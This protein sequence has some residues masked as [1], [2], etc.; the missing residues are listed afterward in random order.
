MKQLFL[1]AILSISCS[2]S[3]AQGSTSYVLAS[4][5][6]PSICMELPQERSIVGGTIIKPQYIGNVSKKIKN[7]FE[8][9]CHLWEEKIP[10]TYPLMIGVSRANLGSSV[11]LARV[12]AF[13]AVDNPDEYR[14]YEKRVMQSSDLFFPEDSDYFEQLDAMIEF[15]SNAP[16]DYNTLASEAATD[17]YDFITVAIQAI[18]KALGF[19]ATGTLNTNNQESLFMQPIMAKGNALRYIGTAANNYIGT[20]AWTS[21]RTITVGS[22]P[23]YTFHGASTTNVTP[24][25]GNGNRQLRPNRSETKH[26]KIIPPLLRDEAF[27][28]P[29]RYWDSYWNYREKS[30]LGKY[31]VLKDGSFEEYDTLTALTANEARYARTVDGFLRIKTISRATGY[32]NT[33]VRY[34]LYSYLPQT[35][36]FEAGEDIVPYGSTLRSTTA[37]RMRNPALPNR[38]NYLVEVPIEFKNTEGCDYIV[39]EQVDSDWPVPYYT[40]VD[41]SQGYYYAIVDT[42]YPSTVKLYYENDNGETEGDTIVINLTG[43]QAMAAMPSQLSV[44]SNNSCLQYRILGNDSRSSDSLQGCYTITNANTGIVSQEGSI[45]AASGRIDVSALPAGVYLITIQTGSQTLSAKWVKR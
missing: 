1:L 5:N 41:P 17:K 23:S 8:Y 15:N 19:S 25:A 45:S 11:I 12:T 40:N 10:T 2:S 42:R 4:D 37:G 7:A 20:I 21:D 38:T 14:A 33:D 44:S 43:S 22:G 9:A 18:F 6:A 35:P 39:A 30:G 26:E 34:G 3:F 36:D 24:Y 13:S 28:F 16:F 29:E 32:N 27:D 31:V